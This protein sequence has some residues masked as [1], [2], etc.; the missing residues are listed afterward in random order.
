M[1][2][3][4]VGLTGATGAMGA[5]GA[6]GA[7][8][9]LSTEYGYVYDN[10]SN[11]T[12]PQN[13][14]VKFSTNGVMTSGIVHAPGS[15]TITVNDAGVYRISFGT[16][17]ESGSFGLLQNG[18]A[19]PGT[20]FINAEFATASGE[21]I[22]SVSAG[23]TFNLNNNS[24]L[25]AIL[26]NQD[27]VPAWIMFVKLADAPVGPTGPTGATGP[28]EDD[29]LVTYPVRSGVQR[30]PLAPPDERAGQPFGQRDRAR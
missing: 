17:A 5:T 29:Q 21:V 15:D 27:S 13:G 22:L 6:T 20:G 24:G 7:T 2:A 14:N 10:T 30:L 16:T 3:T 1:G 12:V 26:F 18:L 4:G 9:S 25:G 19:V 23:D 8:G 11:Q 28:Q